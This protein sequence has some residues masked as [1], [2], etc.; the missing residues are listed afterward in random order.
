MA[1][2]AKK[3]PLRFT[4]IKVK[5]WRNFAHVDVE[6]QRRV[7]LVGAN[8]LGKS[9]FLDIFRFLHDIVSVGGGF[10]EAVRRRRGMT[11]LR[12]LA[13]PRA[14]E[15]AIQADIG[16]SEQSS[17]WAYELSLRQDSMRRPVIKREII[18]KSG[19]RILS[20]P[21]EKD[22][23]D[24]ER[25]TQTAI[26]QVHANQSFR[27]V[28]DFFAS[29]RYLHIVPQ[30]VREPELVSGRREELLGSDF[31]ERIAHTPKAAREARLGRIMQA[32]QV[33]VPQLKQLELWRDERGAPHLR[34][35]YEHWRSQAAWQTEEQFSDGVLRLLGLLWAMLDGAGPLLMEEPELS[36]HPEVV[37]YI[38]QMFARVQRRYG[39]QILLSTHST[40]LLSDEG[41]GLDEVLLLQPGEG[42]SVT[43]AS[44]FEE[45]KALLEG[46]SPLADAV[47][48][49]TR[50]DKAEQLMLFGD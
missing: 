9:N 33:A 39:R 24:P 50:P 38:P 1:A 45:I 27:E 22:K 14:S 19:K 43:P 8:A 2:A 34:G 7:L 30:L 40:E 3:K 44:S 28:A 36:L 42:T 10:H 15:I 17:L 29:V 49:R 23:A 20:R 4:R 41:I 31:L 18:T 47:M 37:R 35:R 32:L 46:G 48:P 25:L 21:N 11:S 5:N 26:E 16:T 12:F 13:A 6:L